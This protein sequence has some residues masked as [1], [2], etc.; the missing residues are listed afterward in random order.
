M[1][2]KWF[3]SSSHSNVGNAVCYCVQNVLSKQS[4]PDTVV[5]PTHTS[6]NVELARI[7]QQARHQ[8]SLFHLLLHGGMTQSVL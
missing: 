4:V 2:P 1:A 6:A 8:F 3:G 7:L 5:L